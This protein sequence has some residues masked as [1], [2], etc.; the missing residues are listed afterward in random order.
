MQ[1]NGPPTY[2]PLTMSKVIGEFY[3]KLYNCLNTDPNHL[4][5][6]EKF[7]SFFESLHMPKI[8]STHLA[9]L[10]STIPPEELAEV[11]KNL[12][13]HKSPGQDGLPY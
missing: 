8:S 11:V 3:H 10:N 6:Q 4:F 1:A 5:T 2:C 7:D 12:P 9:S 13:T